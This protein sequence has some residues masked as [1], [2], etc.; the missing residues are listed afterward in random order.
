MTSTARGVDLPGGVTGQDGGVLPARV[1]HG[2]GHHVLVSIEPS[3][4]TVWVTA[5]VRTTPASSWSPSGLRPVAHN[6]V[7]LMAPVLLAGLIVVELG[8]THWTGLDWHQLLGVAVAGLAR[9]LKLPM[10]PAVICGTT[11]TALLR[12]L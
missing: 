6:V 11:A 12:L 7:T 10:L 4:V 3:R 5:S 1:G 9:A 8:D 2:G